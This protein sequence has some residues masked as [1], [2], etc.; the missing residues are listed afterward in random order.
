M[1]QRLW[2]REFQTVHYRITDFFHN[3]LQNFLSKLSLIT[4]HYF[5]F[6]FLQDEENEIQLFINSL[7]CPK[8]KSPSHCLSK[9]FPIYQNKH[10]TIRQQHNCSFDLLFCRPIIPPYYIADR[11][12]YSHF[13]SIVCPIVP[14]HSYSAKS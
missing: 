2:V 14:A 11:L 5:L 4:N 3:F 8:T 1:V 9:L 12:I 6:Y 7:I 10:W 13:N